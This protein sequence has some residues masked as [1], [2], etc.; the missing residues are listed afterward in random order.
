M[1]EHERKPK[2]VW[3][4]AARIGVRLEPVRSVWTPHQSEA[5]RDDAEASLAAIRARL[6]A[7]EADREAR[8][9]NETRADTTAHQATD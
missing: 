5:Q 7:R 8:A 1:R 4:M 2:T 6:E 3:E 9:E